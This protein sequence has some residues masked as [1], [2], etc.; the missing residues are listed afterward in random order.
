[1]IKIADKERELRLFVKSEREEA[2]KEG[3]KEAYEEAYKEAY[4]EAY[5]EGREEA[6]KEGREEIKR[7]ISE[8]S[9]YLLARNRIEDLERVSHD[10]EYMKQILEEIK[11]QKQASEE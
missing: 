4:E 6:F 2:Y 7:M 11:A 3:Y 8:M 10:P 1:M 5:K 9:L